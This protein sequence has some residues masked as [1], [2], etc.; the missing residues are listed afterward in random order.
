MNNHRTNTLGA[1]QWLDTLK[2]HWNLSYTE[3]RE[4]EDKIVVIHVRGGKHIVLVGEFNKN[5]KIGYILDK[6]C[7]V[8]K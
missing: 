1:K 3:M 8:R 4:S 5:T 2:L 6:R 7:E